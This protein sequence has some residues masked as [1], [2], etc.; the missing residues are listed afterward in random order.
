MFVV[1]LNK[2][3]PSSQRL[4]L[5]NTK[6][7]IFMIIHRLNTYSL[8]NIS[9]IYVPSEI[10][11]STKRLVM[12]LLLF[13]NNNKNS[14]NKKIENTTTETIKGN[15]ETPKNDE[16]ETVNE[17]TNT[18]AEEKYQSTINLD[19]Y[20]SWGADYP[21]I[22]NCRA[23]VEGYF[24]ETTGIGKIKYTRCVF[25]PDNLKN[26]V[27]D[28]KDEYLWL[29]IKF[30]NLTQEKF[31]SLRNLEFTFFDP[32]NVINQVDGKFYEYNGA[33][34]TNQEINGVNYE[35]FKALKF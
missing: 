3:K 34:I 21:H 33:W 25:N 10:F 29:T 16:T 13:L 5:F 6:S 31:N 20:P 9:Q 19:E 14:N 23:P 28:P 17:D 15:T 26:D 1:S 32:D 12:I 4:S 7:D 24:D 2:T 30:S 8:K 22:P 27:G 18:T 11:T 35:S